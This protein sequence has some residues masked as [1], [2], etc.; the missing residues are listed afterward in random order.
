MVGVICAVLLTVFLIVIAS[1][2]KTKSI[3]S[4]LSQ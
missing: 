3:L 4:R 2:E 1:L